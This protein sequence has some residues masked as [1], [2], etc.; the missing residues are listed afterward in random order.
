MVPG[1]DRVRE[2]QSGAGH[3]ESTTKAAAGVFHNQVGGCHAG[4][5]EQVESTAV[6]SRGVPDL[7]AGE[8]G[9][10]SAD[11]HSTAINGALAPS[12]IDQKIRHSHRGIGH[13][14]ATGAVRLKGKARNA[15]RLP[16]V[17]AD[18]NGAAGGNKKGLVQAGE[19]DNVQVLA[20]QGQGLIVG[21]CADL[22]GVPRNRCADGRGN[23]GKRAGATHREGG[24]EDSVVQQ[25]QVQHGISASC[26]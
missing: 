25:Q 12:S 23:G 14:Q 20:R 3:E 17:P 4:L 21:P 2:G 26:A 13:H 24:C 5:V 15:S 6:S 22:D 16:Q 8:R 10:S 1:Q 7:H 19:A 18:S 9:T 11:V